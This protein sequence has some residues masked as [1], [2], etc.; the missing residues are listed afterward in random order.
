MTQSERVTVHTID[1]IAAMVA[2]WM[3]IR[4]KWGR[5]SSIKAKC[6]DL[7]DAYKQVPLSDSAFQ[8]DSFLVGY[9]PNIDAPKIYRQRVL[10]LGSVASVTSFL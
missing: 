7:S 5:S 3:R 8:L 6:W 4:Q 10:P 9:D 2:L 1:H